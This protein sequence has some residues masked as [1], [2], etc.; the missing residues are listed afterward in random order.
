LDAPALL[1]YD[2]PCHCAG[3]Q[4]GV[5]LSIHDAGSYGTELLFPDFDLN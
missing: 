3:L 4:L 2:T 5:G 1:T